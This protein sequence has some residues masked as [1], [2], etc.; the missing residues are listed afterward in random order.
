MEQMELTLF[1][2]IKITHL[3]KPKQDKDQLFFFSFPLNY[4]DT[5]IKSIFIIFIQF[6]STGDFYWQPVIFFD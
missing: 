4:K 1:F 3:C 5:N 2:H 6:Y